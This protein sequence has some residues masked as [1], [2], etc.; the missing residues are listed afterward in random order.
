MAVCR[1]DDRGSTIP[2]ILGFFVIALLM[3]AGSIAL[4]Q[5]FVQQRDLQD[6]CDGAVT[7]AAASSADL[8]RVDGVAAADSL[9]FADV[10]TAVRDYLAR[11][12]RRHD[13]RVQVR[14][15]D[16]RRRIALTC[17]RDAPL[18]FGWLFDRRSVRHLARSA[19]RADLGP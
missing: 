2:L 16:D 11:D 12:P 3:I 19:A 10:G 5:A 1:A 15:T 6:V 4:G 9:R 18:A 7:A 17:S 14:L 8:D 13:V